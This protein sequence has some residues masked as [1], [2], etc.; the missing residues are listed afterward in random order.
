M[1]TKIANGLKE[2]EFQILK[3]FVDV[4]DQLKLKYYLVEGTLLGAI[5]HQGFIPWDDDID[6]GMPRADYERFLQE[7]QALLP[8]YYFVQSM[9]SEPEYHANFAKIRD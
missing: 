2:C 8:D 9:Y 6:V 1:R 5:R 3:A 4:C 7:A